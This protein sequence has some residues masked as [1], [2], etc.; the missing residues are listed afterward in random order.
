MRIDNI[1]T[2]IDTPREAREALHRLA[3]SRPANQPCSAVHCPG[4]HGAQ[5][6]LFFATALDY[7]EKM[8]GS[9]PR[10]DVQLRN[11]RRLPWLRQ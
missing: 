2:H 8:K 9:A 11:S 1:N 7:V 6:R 10:T 3:E 4:G 5:Y